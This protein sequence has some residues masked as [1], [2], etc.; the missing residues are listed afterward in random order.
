[1]N[2]EDRSTRYE[3]KNIQKNSALSAGAVE[4]ANTPLRRGKTRPNEVTSWPWVAT[5]KALGW[6]PG[7][8]AVTDPAT[9]WSMACNTPFSPL[10]GQTSTKNLKSATARK[11]TLNSSI[12]VTYPPSQPRRMG[13]PLGSS[14]HKLE[15]GVGG[16]AQGQRKIYSIYGVFKQK[17]KTKPLRI[18]LGGWGCRLPQIHSY[19]I[20]GGGMPN[21]ILPFPH[22]KSNIYKS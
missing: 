17:I 5:R 7:G 18:R 11:P 4:Y 1:M 20:F 12:L 2:S 16:G 21:Q 13:Y 15:S 3:Q 6:I 10:L 22:R 14:Q 19:W 9:E 8:W